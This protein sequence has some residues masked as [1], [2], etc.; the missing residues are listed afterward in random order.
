ME[1]GYAGIHVCGSKSEICDVR[2]GIISVPRAGLS[3]NFA[4]Q[5]NKKKCH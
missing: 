5:T 2:T 4:I 3:P 1:C